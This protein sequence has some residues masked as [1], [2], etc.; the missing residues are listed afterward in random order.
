MTNN[1]NLDAAMLHEIQHL[2]PTIP[3][4][5]EPGNPQSRQVLLR[6]TPH[7]HDRWKQA[8][9]KMGISMSEF[10]RGC[11]NAEAAELLD[12]SH[13][14]NMRRWYPWSEQCLKCGQRL[15]A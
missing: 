12:C 7:D 14:L 9:E 8:A 5:T 1:N 2:N 3:T 10:I 15:R 13:P 4:N 6:A 11:C